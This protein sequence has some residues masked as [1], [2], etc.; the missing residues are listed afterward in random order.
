MNNTCQTSY[1]VFVRILNNTFKHI[2]HAL[3]VIIKVWVYKTQKLN[4]FVILLCKI[5]SVKYFLLYFMNFD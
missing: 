1:R 4:R 5:K 3:N 2:M